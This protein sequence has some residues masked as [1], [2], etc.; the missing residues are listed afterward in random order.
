MLGEASFLSRTSRVLSA[1]AT[2][3]V[4]AIRIPFAAL[5][6]ILDENKDLAVKIYQALG[7]HLGNVFHKS[8][9]EILRLREQS[10]HRK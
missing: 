10:D 6:E 1:T 9:T 3:D 7:K 8:M 4:N 2:E 5:K